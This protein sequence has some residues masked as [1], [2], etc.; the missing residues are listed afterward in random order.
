LPERLDECFAQ[1]GPVPFSGPDSPDAV[2]DDLIE[3][4]TARIQAGEAVD[5]EEVAR[6]HPE[7]AERLRL[8]LPALVMMAD[9]RHSS[10]RQLEGVDAA[11]GEPGAGPGVLGDF[12]V[13]REI[14]RG[15]MGVVY[16][17]EQISLARRVAL[18]V[19]PLAA[20]MDSKQMQRFQLEA[21]AAA[22]LHHT[23]IVPVHAVG[24][25]RGV[26][27][28]AMQYIEGRSLVEVIRELRRLEGLDTADD[29][30]GL[31]DISTSTLAAKLLS[32]RAGSGPGGPDGGDVGR[33]EW[34]SAPRESAHAAGRDVLGA[35]CHSALRGSATA[36]GGSDAA[37]DTPSEAT[38]PA[39]KREPAPPTPRPGAGAPTGSS[40]RTQEYVRTVAEL[41]VQVAEALD[42]AHTRGILHRDIKPGNLLL[43]EKGQLWVT[44]FGLAQVQGSPGVTL[45]G[46]VLGT[47]RYTSPEQALAKRVVIDGRTDIYSLGVTLYELLTLQPAIDGQDRQEILRRIA[48]AEPTPPRKHN[49]AVPRDFETVLLK[50]I[51]KEPGG[52]YATAK[53]L[54]DELRRFLEHKPV[55]A[56]RPSLL[57]RAA[58]WSRRHWAAVWSTGVASIAFLLVVAAVLAV[59]VV[60]ISHETKQ[61]S[62]ALE[63]AGRSAAESRAVLEFF[64]KQVLAATRPEGEEG[65]L[66]KD[67]TIRAAVDAAE[68]K[69]EDAFRD[70]PAAEASIRHTLGLTYYYLGEPALAIRQHE[71]SR[72]LR[73]QTLSPDHP[74][75]LQSMNDLAIAYLKAGRLNDATPL[76][77]ETL[78]L[79]KAKLGPDDPETLDTANNLAMAYS[80]AGRFND[81]MPLLK[82]TLKLAQAKLGPRQPRTLRFM[83]N[84]ASAHYDAGRP[85]EAL[86]LLEKALELR[87]VVLGPEHPGTI[88]S[89][90]LLARTYRATGRFNQAIPLFEDTLKLAKAKLGANHL[91][92]L[93]TMNNLAFAY[94]DAGKLNEALQLF[95]ATLKL[96]K[97]KLGPDHPSTLSTMNNL[98]NIYRDA[99]RLSEAVPLLEESLELTKVKVGPDHPHTLINMSDLAYAYRDA[100]R[101][102][103]A[104]LLL[105]QALELM[106]AKPGAEHPNTVHVMNNLVEAYLDARRWV[107]AETNARQCQR[108]HEKRQADDWSRYRTMSLLGAALT[109][110]KKYAEAEPLLI[111]GYDGLRAREAKMPARSKGYLAAAAARIV[112]FYQAWGKPAKAAEWRHKLTGQKEVPRP[113]KD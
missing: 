87:R 10:P 94:R 36:V 79:T 67:A 19:L 52:R 47:L 102:S 63:Q 104:V 58:K 72:H 51:A 78:M 18:K 54:A 66:S 32:G 86:P 103:E 74:D 40:T 109:A 48:E 88:S 98:G 95:E 110:Q 15:G 4:L 76:L 82:E 11:A 56:R 9:F 112:P 105:E 5:V 21:H 8:L 22:C 108:L 71:R 46:D 45:T 25:E 37:H 70:Q 91:D 39:S 26:P 73:R 99:G 30:A 81:A 106:K 33:A 20:A 113:T 34:H 55:V 6:R 28:Y 16:E 50:A 97:T 65:G 84:L 13:L 75:M 29:P 77:E 107:E 61:K 2:L 90:H 93:S 96:K 35:E 1:N 111:D 80:E 41:G 3:V 64:Q 14:G 69:I 43:D 23:N 7:Y 27:F 62:Q 68:P 31:A 24:C 92:T 101:L 85:N 59:S 17:A 38:P 42:H 53:E 44:D 12:R 89:M 49:A 57:D 83:Q 100:G 60:R